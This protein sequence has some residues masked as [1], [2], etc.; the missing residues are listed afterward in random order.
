[1]DM[2]IRKYVQINR[3][4]YTNHHK[5]TVDNHILFRTDSQQ[6]RNKTL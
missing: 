1:M 2:S 4:D 3:F 5:V 6:I